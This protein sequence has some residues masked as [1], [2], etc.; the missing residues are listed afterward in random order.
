MVVRASEDES[1]RVI[2]KESDEPKEASIDVVGEGDQ[3]ENDMAAAPDSRV[4]GGKRERSPVGGQEP[5]AK[6]ARVSPEPGPPSECLAPPQD[7]RIAR[8][9]STL[10]SGVPH[11]EGANG[12]SQNAVKYLGAGDVFLTEGWRDRWC[13]CKDVRFIS[14]TLYVA[15]KVTEEQCLPS[16]QTRPYLLEEE[17][18]YEPPEDPDSGMPS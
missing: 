13:H 9:L 15:Q 18:T 2:G 10:D 7:P 8:V 12:D 5:E 4:T 1:W 14:C 17:E 16:L 3:N 6:R 11:N